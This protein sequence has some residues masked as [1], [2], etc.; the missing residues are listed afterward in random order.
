MTHWTQCT[1]GAPGRPFMDF[2]APGVDVDTPTSAR[3]Y[4]Y[5]LGG[6]QNFEQD[7]IV[8]EKLNSV[9][10]FRRMARLNREFLVKA[11]R[12][13][14]GRGV[15]QFLDIGSGIPTAGSVHETART[16]APDSRVVYVDRDPTAVAH[17]RLLLDAIE[18]VAIIEAD[19]HD[20][21]SIL[22]H[23]DT[24]S[25][26]DFTEPVG[27]LFLG[28]VQYL[29]DSADPAELLHRYIDPLASGSHLALTHFTADN[30]ETEMAAAVDFFAG[31]ASPMYPR[32]QAAI[33]AL[34][35]GL[36]LLDP[37]VVFTAR[38]RPEPGGVGADD[39]DRSG[40]YAGVGRKP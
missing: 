6:T 13:L 1:V 23:P 8:A 3:I 21:D 5:M 24:Q 19:L 35:N 11:V 39:P 10:P 32:G 25:I 36:T 38:W 30:F 22:Q 37:G 34:F 15:T 29:P 16:A 28:V 33:T 14:A 4:D 27:L 2:S 18:G 12:L 7:R 40:H 31:T 20:P 17:S 9:A 26:I